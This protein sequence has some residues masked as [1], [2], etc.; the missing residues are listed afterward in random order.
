M[1]AVRG[2]NHIS[3]FVVGRLVRFAIQLLVTATVVFVLL[4]LVPGDPAWVMLGEQASVERVEALREEL[5]LNKPLLEQYVDWL[6]SLFRFKLGKSIIRGQDATGEILSRLVRTLALSVGALVLAVGVGLPLG[7]V[8]AMRRGSWIDVGLSVLAVVG[9]SVPVF[10]I[11]TLMALYFSVTLGW[12]PVAGYVGFAQNP[13]GSLHHA[14]L[15][16]VALSIG[17]LAVTMRM[18]RS[19][20]LEVM[21]QDYVRT[22]RAKGLSEVAVLNR[23]VV[24]NSM[25]PVVT[26]LGYYFGQTLGTSILTERVFNW[27]GLSTLLIEGIQQR[28]Y[29]LVQGTILV[30]VAVFLIINLL[31]DVGYAFL[32]PRI[33]YE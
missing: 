30:I 3:Q 33:R 28:D 7:I 13:V 2:G 17:M 27:P 31:V 16:A 1:Q 21:R 12:F 20:T 4:R 29:P 10:V 32:D 6:S 22:G 5:G 14:V 25:I 24:R 11:G 26:V 18:V 8:A 19:T 15:P 9:F 23:Y